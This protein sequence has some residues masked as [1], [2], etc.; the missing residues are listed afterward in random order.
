MRR[1]PVALSA[2]LILAICLIAAC[3]TEQVTDQMPGIPVTP[4]AAPSSRPTSQG[5]LQALRRPSATPSPAPLTANRSGAVSAGAEAAGLRLLS[6]AGLAPAAAAA[7][8][9]IEITNRY[10]EGDVLAYEHVLAPVDRFPSTLEAVTLQEL[11]DGWTGRQTSP[12]FTTIFPSREIVA[13]LEALLGPAG[14]A[15]K[16]QAPED[17]SAA[18]WGDPM[19]IGIVPFDALTPRLR[20]LDVDGVSVVDNHL[21]SSDW[22]LASRVWL[23]P[24]TEQGRQAVTRAAAGRPATNRDL[25]KLT[26]LAVTGVTAIARNTA[27]AIEQAGD[28]AFPARLVGPD[29]AGAD[30]T[31]T[32]NEI[33]F[34]D[35]C[36]PD[37]SLGLMLFCAKPEYYATL[38]LSGID[39]VGLTGNHLN[40]FGY[41]NTLASLDFY[42][43]KGM[44]VYGGGADEVAARVPLILEH[45][46]NRLAFLGANQFGPAEYE[47]NGPGPVSAWAGPDNPGAAFFDRAQMIADIQAVKPKVDLVFAEVQ[48]TEFNA[49][50]DYQIEPL[51]EQVE[52]FQALIDGGADVVTGV[53]AH[54]PQAVELPD[55]S[56]ILYGLGNLY[57]DQTWSWPTRTG[58]VAWHT[59]YEGRLLNTH[60]SVTVIDPDFQVRWATPEERREVLQSVFNASTW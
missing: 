59:V 49:A 38:E 5:V 17:V 46:G 30:L 23:H 37:N 52:D 18:V 60:L 32:S 26:V 25:H 8:S 11:R 27:A 7:E 4:S 15:V 29:L 35:G 9:D 34:V 36:V 55:D 16:P 50:G 13:E 57:F 20:S 42:R 56:L 19:S 48:H 14:P 41:E 31:I 51:P 6:E 39:A 54:A 28:Y 2:C 1:E 45:N 22:P 21:A 24:R 40:D 12:H 33:S 44:P 47:P 10:T 53:Q 58:L 43:A 3:G